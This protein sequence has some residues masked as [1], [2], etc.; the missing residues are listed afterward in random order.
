MNNTIMIK[1]AYVRGLAARGILR[2]MIMQKKASGSDSKDYNPKEDLQ[3]LQSK[4]EEPDFDLLPL[5]IRRQVTNARY[6]DTDPEFR[7]SLAYKY[8]NNS[9]ARDAGIPQ[10]AVSG[11]AGAGV[12]GAIGAL[13]Q[14]ARKKNVLKGALIGGG[15]GAG[16]GIGG[17]YINDKYIYPSIQ[18]KHLKK[19]QLPRT[20]E[21]DLGVDTSVIA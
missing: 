21:E 8:L 15:I 11:L 10:Y 12:M 13:I 14:A 17:K 7:K 6:L 16:I 4:S 18:E 1:Q 3:D 2:A 5:G 20:A 19:D 9:L